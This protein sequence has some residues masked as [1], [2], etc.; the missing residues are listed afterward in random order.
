MVRN[1]E[2][3]QENCKRLQNFEVELLSKIKSIETVENQSINLMSQYK[4]NL[5]ALT[6]VQT[7]QNLVLDELNLIEN[8]LDS[9]LP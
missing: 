3:F 1:T 5:K 4:D 2:E 9:I 8:E 7:Q 6:N